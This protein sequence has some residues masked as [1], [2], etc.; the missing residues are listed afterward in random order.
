M[1]VVIGERPAAKAA[2]VAVWPAMTEVLV[3]CSD[4]VTLALVAVK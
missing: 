1:F 3:G 2:N 4:S